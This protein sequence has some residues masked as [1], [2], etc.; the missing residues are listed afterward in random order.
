MVVAA[1]FVVAAA[2]FAAVAAVDVVIADVAVVVRAEVAPASYQQTFV[3]AVVEQQNARVEAGNKPIHC[4]S[5]YC[6]RICRCV[7][8]V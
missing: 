4:V 2:V 7:C 8:V 6:E 5:L 1:V 3:A